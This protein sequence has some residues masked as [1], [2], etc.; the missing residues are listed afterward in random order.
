MSSLPLSGLEAFA[1]VAETGSFAGAAERLHVSQS[2]VSHRIRGL[3]NQLQV[4][5][6]IREGRRAVLTE[7]GRQVA[8]RTIKAF[9]ELRS[10]TDAM[11]IPAQPRLNLSCSPSFAI[12]FLVPRLPQWRKRREGVDIRIAADDRLHTP[13]Q[14]EIDACIRYGPG[15]YP[16]VREVRLAVETITPVCS[17]ALKLTD[18]EQLAEVALLHDEVL[19][20]HPG[21]IGWTE[22]LKA[23]GLADIDPTRGPRFS[24]N[25]M[26]LEAALAGQ[27]VALGRSSLVRADLAAGRLRAPFGLHLES[28]L[29]YW[30]LTPSGTT[31]PNLIDFEDWLQTQIS[32]Q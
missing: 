31:D 2:A 20:D 16:A 19:R 23:A 4:E 9:R 28:G 8:S 22:W 1:A 24:H 11:S 6:F 15:K 32:D 25:Y 12:R 5:L 30:W 7:M 29:S 26:A 14:S 10:I 18:L 27:G 21:R 17:P 3:E 13:G